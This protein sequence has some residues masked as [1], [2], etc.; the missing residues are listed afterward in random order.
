MALF[1]REGENAIKGLYCTECNELKSLTMF[2]KKVT[3]CKACE[4]NIVANYSEQPF[5]NVE[6][7]KIVMYH[8]CGDV[9]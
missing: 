8:L 4:K 7:F 5:F 3:I 9:L 6:H 1:Y 2:R